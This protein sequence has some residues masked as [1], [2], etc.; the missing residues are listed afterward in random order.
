M[1]SALRTG[2]L[3]KNQYVMRSKYIFLL[4]LPLFMIA[5]LPSCDE[6]TGSVGIGMIEDDDIVTPGRKTFP[7]ELENLKQAI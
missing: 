2:E 6:S 5:L 3:T 7:I 1:Q 4:F